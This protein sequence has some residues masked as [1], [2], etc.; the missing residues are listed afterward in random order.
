[1]V[2]NSGSSSGTGAGAANIN[3]TGSNTKSSIKIPIVRTPPHHPALVLSP[4]KEVKGSDSS[5][6]V[7]TPCTVTCPR[8]PGQVPQLQCVRCLCLY[9]HE[10]VGLLPQSTEYRTVRHKVGKEYICKVRKFNNI[11]I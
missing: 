3:A 7:V 8:A 5:S 1:M 11:Y 4:G 10:C 6:V 9:H 2:G